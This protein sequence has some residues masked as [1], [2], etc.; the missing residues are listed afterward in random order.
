[1]A[2]MTF[3]THKLVRK[4]RHAGFEERQAEG[5]SD[6]LKDLEF[7]QELATR[8]DVEV[9]RQDVRELGLRSE[10]TFEE[11]RGDMKA[12]K[13]MLGISVGGVIALVM[14]QFFP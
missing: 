7:G 5:L 2:T 4:L 1:M 6:V 8:R 3:D 11:L 14:K 12:V 10:A 9:V 13:W